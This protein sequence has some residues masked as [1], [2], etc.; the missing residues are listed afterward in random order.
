VDL[1]AEWADAVYY[2]ACSV[3]V[4]EMLAADVLLSLH[5]V[6]TL[7]QLVVH[8]EPLLVHAVVVT[9]L[10][11]QTVA[12]AILADV[13]LATEPYAEKYGF[14]KSSAAKFQYVLP[15]FVVKR[16]LTPTV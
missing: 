13:H 6:A 5:A 11:V 16:S 1:E 9:E 8:V 7:L 4:V 15:S 12:I 2:L 3:V 14:Q 10:L